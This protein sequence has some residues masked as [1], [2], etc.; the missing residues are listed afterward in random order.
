MLKET[1]AGSL[2]KIWCACTKECAIYTLRPVVFQST[3]DKLKDLTNM[4]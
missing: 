4:T 2:G 1:P 3:K